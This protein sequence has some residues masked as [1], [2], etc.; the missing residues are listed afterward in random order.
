MPDL[1]TFYSSPKVL[2]WLSLAG[3]YGVLEAI[4]R[5]FRHVPPLYR[6]L[7]ARLRG[8]GHDTE[9]YYSYRESGYIIMPGGN[10]FVNSRRERVVAVKKL[11]EVP[12]QYTWTGEGE[13]QEELFPDTYEIR[14]LAGGTGQKPQ[15]RV[16]FDATL[17]KGR[18]TEYTILLKCKRTGREPQPF[19]SSRS[20]HRVDELLLR[21][22]FPA[23]LLPERVFYIRRNSDEIEVHREQIKER[24]RLTG[25]F[26]RL[27][28]YA[29][30]HESHIIE[31]QGSSAAE[32]RK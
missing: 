24:D 11:E 22:V 29:E 13:V 21:V 25:E 3:A 12:F 17:E 26:R 8:R 23:N 27:V 18:E 28:K 9:F 5:F 19:L 2:F 10:E 31:W 14:Q 1:S 30:P 6:S 16:R 4:G 7:R 20:S 15:K 32:E